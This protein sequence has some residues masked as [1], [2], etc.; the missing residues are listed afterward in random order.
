M[1]VLKQVMNTGNVDLTA[2]SVMDPTV[3]HSCGVLG[4]LGPG[5]QISCPGFYTLTW[6]EINAE[7]KE[8]TAK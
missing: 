2:V 4:D 8:N 1:I 6:L 3:V 5:K 7:M